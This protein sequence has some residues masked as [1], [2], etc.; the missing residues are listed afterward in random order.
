MSQLFC[1]ILCREHLCIILPYSIG[2]KIA[3]RE[4]YL[5]KVKLICLLIGFVLYKHVTKLKGGRVGGITYTTDL[6]YLSYDLY[7]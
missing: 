2:K 1:V 7:N 3:I 6:D 5:V 4:I